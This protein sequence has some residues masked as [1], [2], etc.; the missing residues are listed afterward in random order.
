LNVKLEPLLMHVEKPGRYLGGEVNA[1]RK[2][3]AENPVHVALAFPDVYEVGM[4]HFGLHILYA[5]LNGRPG[6]LAERFYAPWPDMEG[7]LRSAGLPLTSLE[8]SRPLSE[9]DLVGFSL[10]YEL[11]FT[12]VLAMLNL[13]GIPLR[14]ASRREDDPLVIAG[15]PC[16]FQPAPMAPFC[17]AFVIG[18]GEEVVLEI[19][20]VI[21]EG[22]RKGW[23]REE[24]LERLSDLAGVY[25]P[26]I[27]RGHEKISKRIVA[28]LDEWPLPTSPVIPLIRTI[29]DRM[30]LEIA[31]GCTRGCRFCQAGMVWRPVRE[32]RPGDLVHAA[33]AMLACTGHN[34]LSL[35]SLSSG[36]YSLIEP[37]MECLMSRYQAKRVAMSL[38]SLRPET[39]TKRLIEE[40][41]RVR[42]TSFTLAP[43]AGTQRLRNVINKGNTEADLL[44]TTS[45]VFDAGWKAVKLY[46]MIGLPS[47]TEGDIEGIA[48]LAHR[49]LEEGRYRGQV[50]VNL[51]TFV[52]KPH[53][54][55]Q[56]QRQMSPEETLEKQI[57]IRKL[58]RHRQISV[59]WH[60]GRMSLLE[61]LLS[62]G[63]ES[64]ADLIERAFLAGCRFDGWSDRMRF[65]HWQQA[66][67]ACGMDRQAILEKKAPNTSLPW[68]RIDTGV[69]SDYL[70]REAQRAE[71]GLVTEDCRAGL[72]SDCGVCDGQGI[73]IR[74]VD[75]PQAEGIKALNISLLTALQ[76]DPEPKPAPLRHEDRGR[77]ILM[78]Y[79]KTGLARFLS[80]LE[81]ATAL[82]RA[83]SMAGPPLEF[84]QGF[85]PLPRIAFPFA[86][87]VGL[88]SL[89]EYAGILLASPAVLQQNVVE[90]INSRL[91]EGLNVLH[92]EE[93][94]AGASSLSQAIRTFDYE[95]LWDEPPDDSEIARLFERISDFFQA[96]SHTVNREREGRTIQKD[97]RPYV[98]SLE[99]DRA[100]AKILLKA[101]IAPDGTV[102]P[103]EVLTSILGIDPVRALSMRVRKVATHMQLIS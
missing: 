58:L 75:D 27:H 85:H 90:R 81:T 10:Q 6:M 59:K 31:R 7:R 89:G 15:G 86:T 43:E 102:R 64:V 24:R 56:W 16:S 38:P 63:D 49:V 34:E 77:R 70:I 99:L 55:F 39:L 35:L 32:R 4:S 41:R 25:V 67:E 78:T 45:R 82:I 2:N 95:I 80:H 8:S 79:A 87:P 100:K 88:E 94:P 17:D 61:G 98:L 54:P 91:P 71:G 9:F 21:G 46:F 14:A 76:E 11:S 30:V 101:G 96:S 36:D 92:L 68:E 51:S 60:D 48:N 12:N 97:I 33:D 40:I 28:N 66:M 26:S 18:E 44:A 19:A 65:D 42:K 69:R 84:S 52:P 73:R 53:T 20:G 83:F 103:M 22:K 13:S 23:R 29:H 3:W 93:I 47:E 1:V 5:I 72:C 74:T 50:T 62:R 57:F 37:L